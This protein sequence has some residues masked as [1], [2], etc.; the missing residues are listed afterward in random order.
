MEEG[1]EAVAGSR[2]RMEIS[3]RPS[4]SQPLAACGSHAITRWRPEFR[5]DKSDDLSI[6]QINYYYCFINCRLMKNA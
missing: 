4:Q 5:P 2:D 6:P 3:K 1:A